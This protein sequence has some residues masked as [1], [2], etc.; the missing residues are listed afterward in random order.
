L[1]QFFHGRFSII[2][3]CENSHFGVHNSLQGN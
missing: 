2:A 3:V 1:Q